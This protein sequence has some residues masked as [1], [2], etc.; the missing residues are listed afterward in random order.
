MNE[1]SDLEQAQKRL[2][3]RRQQL[4]E[5]EEQENGVDAIYQRIL[6]KR[7]AQATGSS[8]QSKQPEAKGQQEQDNNKTGPQDQSIADV[9]I[10]N[11]KKNNGKLAKNK[12][13]LPNLAVQARIFPPTKK[14]RRPLF[15]W[16]FIPSKRDDVEIWQRGEQLNQLDLT[17]WLMLIRFAKG[18]DLVAEFTRYEF[19]RAMRR[20]DSSRDYR[21]LRSFLDRIGFTQFAIYLHQEDKKW[22]RYS[23]ALAPQDYERSD[24]LHAVQLSKP[25][26]ALFGFDGWSFI[27]VNQRLA[28]GQKQWAQAFHAWCS[29]NKCPVNGFWWK[30]EE[31]QKEWGLEYHHTSMFLK[32]FRRR[33]LKPLYDIDFIKKVEEKKT[34]IGLWW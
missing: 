18:P 26:Y 14:G 1:K 12:S 23:G 27:D 24:G 33:V 13:Q 4:E 5:S 22:E 21:W 15:D 31:L 19:L 34:V 30:K 11:F 10:E 29:A 28:L 20:Q 32:D 9:R 16:R 3:Q 8:E 25:L 2:E 17:G 6:E 7:K